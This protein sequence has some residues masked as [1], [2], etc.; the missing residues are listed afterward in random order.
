MVVKSI[1]YGETDG[2]CCGPVS[3]PSFVEI[4][5][6]DDKGISH[7]IQA[8]VLDISLQ[9]IISDYPLFDI[10]YTAHNS[11]A[12]DFESEYEKAQ[13]LM[14]SEDEYDASDDEEDGY[15]HY[16]PGFENAV[17]LAVHVLK[18]NGEES[19]IKKYLDEEI[20]NIDIP[21]GPFYDEEE[22]Y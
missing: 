16:Y 9:I 6:Y 8:S 3:G 22:D 12:A 2:V 15:G 20:D 10:M 1:R 7:F 4:M 19:I 18:E 13:K 5:V 14:I 21:C 17:N 11:S